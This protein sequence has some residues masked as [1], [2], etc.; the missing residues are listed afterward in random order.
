MEETTEKTSSSLSIEKENKENVVEAG[1]GCD[2]KSMK[3][4]RMEETTENTNTSASSSL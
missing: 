3:K 4:E 1:C 2:V